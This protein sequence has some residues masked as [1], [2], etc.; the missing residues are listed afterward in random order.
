MIYPKNFEN[1]IGFDIVRDLIR[2]HC[3]NRLGLDYV[4]QIEFLSDLPTISTLTDQTE[5][6][7]KI[8]LSGATFP[9]QD[10]VDVTPELRNLLIEGSVIDLDT[11]FG[12]KISLIS[13]DDCFDFF[14]KKEYSDLPALKKLAD[15][16]SCNPDLSGI[17]NGIVDDKGH[18]KDDASPELR[19]I[20]RELILKSNAAAKR[21]MSILQKTKKEGWANEDAELTVRNGRLVIPITAA[22]KRKIKGFVHDES[23]TG[24]TVFIEPDEIFEINNEIK[25]LEN[26]EKREIYRI[27]HEFTQLIRPDIPIIL[28][29][30]RFLGILDFI[31]AKALFAIDINASKPV[32]TGK[33]EAEWINARHPLLFLSHKAQNKK[34]VPMSLAL[35]QN[36]RILVVSGPN[37]GG[38]SVCLKTVGLLQYMLQ[39][40]LLVSMDDQSQVGIFNDIFVNI[41]DEQSLEDDLS[42]YSS[43]LLAMKFFISNASPSTLFLIDEFG[44]GTEPKIGGAIA[45][46]VLEKLNEKKSFGVVTTHYAN[47]K[48]FASNT[49]GI[50]NGAMMFDSGKLQPLYKLITGN[51]GSSFAIEIA[52]KIGL[53]NEVIQQAKKKAGSK[54]IDF[55]RQLMDLELQK[56]TLEKKEAELKMADE[57]LAEMIDK[58]QNLSESLEI[59]KK[60]IMEKA[61]EEARDLLN[62]SNS[63]IEKTI[64]EIREKNAEKESTKEVR[65]ILKE[66][67]DNI[68]KPALPE[69][70]KTQGK[71]LLQK[72]ESFFKKEK[73]KK[74]VVHVIKTPIDKGDYVRVIGQTTVGEVLSCDNKEALVIFGNSKIK[75]TLSNLEKVDRKPDSAKQATTFSARKFSLDLDK[76][77]AKFKTSIDIRGYKAEDALNYAQKYIDEALLLCIPEVR[78]LHGKGNGILRNIIREYLRTVREVKSFRDETLE[79]G[80]HGITVVYFR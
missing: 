56:N 13:I 78:I 33:P 11:L 23:A 44:S 42:T 60:E 21:I 17:I 12:L 46:A 34:V 77:L 74:A 1:K 68:A 15:E 9:L 24:Q 53:Q 51:P 31:R 25:D 7:R 80:G 19:R 14:K 52:E 6:F 3:I 16:F 54:E 26:D 37:A 36:Q 79:Q 47:L 55:E 4:E 43:H 61:R 76:K 69:K 63:L 48:L 39:C 70:Q 38:K 30:F 75:T 64:K 50:F 49:D 10:Y 73:Q 18:V 41:G 71:Q 40:G 62:R 45:E 32:I 66:F 2:K 29:N 5:E 8:I 22:H 20:R 65:T 67:A 35:N 72:D 57:F 59:R 58:Y 27:L 28:E